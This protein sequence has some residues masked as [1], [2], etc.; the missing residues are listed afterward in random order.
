PRSGDGNEEYEESQNEQ[1]DTYSAQVSSW[2]YFDGLLFL[3][4]Q[5]TPRA[6]KGNLGQDTE[7]ENMAFFCLLPHIK[8]LNDEQRMLLTMEIQQVTYRHVYGTSIQQS[9]HQQVS[10][11]VS[12]SRPPQL[13]STIVSHQQQPYSVQQHGSQPFSDDYSQSL[14][15]RGEMS[16][17]AGGQYTN[18]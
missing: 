13:L 1:D 5:F 8:K 2:T 18:I 15:T 10:A 11:P 9:Q 7:D 3:K 12:L 17:P 16:L 14:I 6:N 4:D